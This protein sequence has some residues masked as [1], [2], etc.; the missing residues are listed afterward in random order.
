MLSRHFLGYLQSN[1]V[2]VCCVLLYYAWI[3]NSDGSLYQAAFCSCLQFVFI[4]YRIRKFTN[5]ENYSWQLSK[6]Q[7]CRFIFS[8]MKYADNFTGVCLQYCM[9]HN[10]Q[11]YYTLHSVFTKGLAPDTCG[12]CR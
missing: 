3:Y 2:K 12:V 10:T 5:A 7:C 8:T 4:I 11:L 1:D 9:Q 6:W